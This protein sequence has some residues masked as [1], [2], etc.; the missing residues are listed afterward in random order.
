[1]ALSATISAFDKRNVLVVDDEASMRMALELSFGQRGW[2][3]DAA[4]G[5]REA[6]EQFRRFHHRLVVSDVRMPDGDGLELLQALRELAP[7]TAVILLTAFGAI[8]DAVAA[9]KSGACEYLTK[10]VG[11]EQL[12]DLAE[13]ILAKKTVIRH[14]SG[15]MVGSSPALL[16]A[17]ERAQMAA[18]SDSDVLIEAESGT[19]KELLA[20]MV[21]AQSRRSQHSFIAVNCAALPGELLESELF[22]YAR[23]AFTG[24]IAARAGKFADSD[25][26]TLLLDEVGELPLSLQPKLLRVLQ[27]REFC[28]LGESRPVKVDVRVIATTN[29]PLEAMVAEGG[30]RA[31]LYYRL[32]VLPLSLPPLRERREDI[33]E[34]ALHFARK[35]A[36][37]EL[38]P[39]LPEPF[40]AQLEQHCWP[41][42]VRELANVVRRFTIFG[43]TRS[44]SPP[45]AVAPA[46]GSESGSGLVPAS[47]GAT[48]P[49]PT[50]MALAPGVSL[51][52]AER[53]L[54]ELT[55]NATAGNR[56]RAAEM[57]GISL[58]TVRN[59]IREYKLPAR[60]EYARLHD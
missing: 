29:R 33:R 4:T 59:K 46:A 20:R 34:L 21:H 37:W 58:R 2:R 1:M 22:G 18:E 17:L 43:R 52:S 15:E 57:L 49:M 31:D 53:Q 40:L 38:E 55:L 35:C 10:P 19:G 42:N 3:V 8:P 9:M 41:G 26:G 6:L 47:L 12:L 5:K 13:Q 56:S 27:E 28:R 30:F 32:N 44:D 16:R 24:A 48:S 60:R 7:Q 50:V 51:A 39:A 11:F 14:D 23:G 25:G 54:L 36:G 45:N